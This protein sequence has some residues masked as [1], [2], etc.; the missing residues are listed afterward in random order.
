MPRKARPDTTPVL[1]Q[2]PDEVHAVADA[3]RR[4]ESVTWSK[5]IST[6]L[7]RWAAGDDDAI[8]KPVRFLRPAL[9]EAE[10]AER[11]HQRMMDTNE[12]YR[13]AATE[14]VDA[15][16]LP[17]YPSLAALVAATAAREGRVVSAEALA[18]LDD[19][20]DEVGGG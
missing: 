7:A 19:A 11:W 1:A 17:R 20:D 6:L 14:K 16:K 15:S 13:R 2:I 10:E 5:V 18:E 8:G 3:R 9:P 12:G 4:R